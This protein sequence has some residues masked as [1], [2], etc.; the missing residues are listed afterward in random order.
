MKSYS[1]VPDGNVNVAGVVGLSATVQKPKIVTFSGWT[2]VVSVGVV[3]TSPPAG[4]ALV[5]GAG[6]V[7]D[8]IVFMGH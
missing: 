2:N 6:F 8:D 7:L 5:L 3:A 1:Y 4:T